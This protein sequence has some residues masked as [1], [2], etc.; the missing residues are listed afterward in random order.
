MMR[1]LGCL[2]FGFSIY[3]MI[4]A[5]GVDCLLWGILAM[6]FSVSFIIIS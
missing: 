3:K 4:V 5:E 1:L 2:L 6:I